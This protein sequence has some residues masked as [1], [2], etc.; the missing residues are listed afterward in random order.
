MI[1]QSIPWEGYHKANLISER[2][3]D[4][5]RKYDKKSFETRSALMQKVFFSLTLQC[6]KLTLSKE[7]D[8]YAEL[9]LDLLVKINKEE[10]LQYLLTLIDSLLSSMYLTFYRGCIE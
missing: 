6:L 7:G 3:L 5:I 9:F 4:L 10:T 8:I 1:E 2:E